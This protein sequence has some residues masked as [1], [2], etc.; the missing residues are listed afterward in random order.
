MPNP[1]APPIALPIVGPIAG[2]IT[3]IKVV[4]L[5]NRLPINAPAIAFPE[6]AASAILF[7]NP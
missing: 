6:V 4:K 7:S 3:G 5:P 2:P 1:I